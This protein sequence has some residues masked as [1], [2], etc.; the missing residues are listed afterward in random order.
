MNARRL[1]AVLGLAVA[2]LAAASCTTAA[3]TPAKARADAAGP[4]PVLP[5]DAAAPAGKPLRVS[6]LTFGPGRVYWERF[7]HDAILVRNVATGSAIAYNYGIFDFRQKNFFLNFALG[8][9]RYRM[10]ADPFDADLGFYAAHGRSVVEQS[11][12]LTPAER[13]SL[14]RFLRWNVLPANTGYRYDY[15]LSNCSTRVRD[16]LNRALG[17]KLKPQL[18]ARPA[19]PGHSY[20]F[21]AVRALSPD[22]GLAMIMDIALG[23]AAD[24]ALNRWQDSF[25]PSEL[26]RALDTVRT[27]N[28]HGETVPLVANTRLLI[29]GKVTPMPAHPPDWLPLLLATG[30]ALAVVLLL[31]N[32]ARRC[33]L[34]RFAFAT[35]ASLTTLGLGLAGMG[36]VLIWAV[37]QHWAGWHNEDLLLFD[38]LSLLLL[39]AWLGSARRAWRVSAFSRRLGAIIAVLAVAAL[40][41]RILPGAWQ[42]NLHWIALTAPIHAA[43]AACLWLRPAR[44]P[45][46]A[47]H[48]A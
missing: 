38:P 36:L 29:A 32:Y 41:L 25:L 24:Q 47:Q 1:L 44:G 35:L 33:R 48:A 14:V 18:S 43:L 34:A 10:A 5:A 28:A 12:N 19:A 23:P 31:L 16:A 42:A 46:H 27:T 20:R 30:V 9:M 11:L 3:A 39:P 26:G 7:G 8:N 13:L 21:D 2:S 6:V 40:G 37:T 22:T 4:P 15:F 17:G 45:T